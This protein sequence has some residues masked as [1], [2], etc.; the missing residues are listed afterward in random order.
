MGISVAIW[1]LDIYNPKL[2]HC[3]WLKLM[4][5]IN[6][7]AQTCATQTPMHKYSTEHMRWITRKENA[8]KCTLTHFYSIAK[9]LCELP[10]FPPN[11]LQVNISYS[12]FSMR[13]STSHSRSNIQTPTHP[14][15]QHY[16]AA[17]T[18]TTMYPHIYWKRTQ[19]T[20]ITLPERYVTY[21]H[22]SLVI[23]KKRTFSGKSFWWKWVKIRGSMYL[24]VGISKS[25]F[26]CHSPMF[27]AHWLCDW[28]QVHTNSYP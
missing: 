21:F 8:H 23:K 7:P 20:P 18:S 1:K 5:H 28:I 22:L 26:L 3:F 16:T 2:C 4:M 13:T 10:Q 11:H 12:G 15:I 6:T 25:F 19:Q 14:R 27:I 17:Q 9:T 24:A